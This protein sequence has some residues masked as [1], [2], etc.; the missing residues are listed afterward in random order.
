[1]GLNGVEI[2]LNSSASHAEL[3][4]L[5]QR[6]ELI[7]NSTRKL[8]GIYVY[9]NASGVDGEARMMYDGSSMV[10]CNGKVLAQGAQFSLKEVEVV[11]ATIDLEQ[12]RSFRSSISRNVQAAAQPDF[13]RAECDLRVSRPSHE[14]YLSQTLKISKEISLKILD[15]MEEIYCSTAVFLWQY[16]ALF[17]V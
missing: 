16:S 11:T 17:R 4:K 9:A 8:G 5:R 15:P 3:R 10:L 1:M 2:I 6:L 14:V 12:V 7:S 13:Y